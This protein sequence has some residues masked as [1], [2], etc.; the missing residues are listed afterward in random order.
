MLEWRAI[1]DE[2]VK[3]EKGGGEF[4]EPFINYN[5]FQ[6]HGKTLASRGNLFF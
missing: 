2:K 6:H 5:L 1:R 4:I 3:G